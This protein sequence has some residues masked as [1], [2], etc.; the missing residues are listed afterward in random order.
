[1]LSPVS[2]VIKQSCFELPTSVLL[3]GWP[4][5]YNWIHFIWRKEPVNQQLQQQ[6]LVHSQ[7]TQTE[8]FHQSFKTI[9][10]TDWASL[11][12]LC[13]ACGHTFFP[14]LKPVLRLSKNNSLPLNKGATVSENHRSHPCQLAVLP[15]QYVTEVIVSWYRLAQCIIQ[16]RALDDV[17]MKMGL[18][19]NK[20]WIQNA[21]SCFLTTQRGKGL[22]KREDIKRGIPL[23]TVLRS[24]E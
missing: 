7:K 3:L 11:Q 16:M 24:S 18:S 14:F 20:R 4:R 5:A 22:P 6:M 8:S 15:Q 12:Q 9:N 10:I 21:A 1:M 19:K 23:L 2:T 13:C 17:L